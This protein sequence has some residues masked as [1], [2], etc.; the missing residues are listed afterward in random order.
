[1]RHVTQSKAQGVWSRFLVDA[2]EY[3]QPYS[4]GQKNDFRGAEA[5]AETAQRPIMKF[6][7]PK[8]ADQLDLRALHRV[9][10]RFQSAQGQRWGT[11]GAASKI[12]FRPGR[13]ERD[14]RLAFCPE[15]APQ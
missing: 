14:V 4:K 1:L 3:V 9:R 11:I 13:F 10:E 5:I 6:V 2:G 15:L 7:A 8:T 12:L